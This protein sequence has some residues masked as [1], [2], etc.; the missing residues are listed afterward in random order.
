MAVNNL[1]LRVEGDKLIVEMDLS[2]D[3]KFTQNH[4][5]ILIAGTGGNLQLW[6]DGKPHPKGIR[7]NLSCFRPLTDEEK[8]RVKEERDRSIRNGQELSHN[9]DLT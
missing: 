9:L 2:R 6:Q 1:T 7:L 5:S 4:R 8:E 3:L